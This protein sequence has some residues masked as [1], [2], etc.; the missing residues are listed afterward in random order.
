VIDHCEDPLKIL[1]NI[2]E[3]A[4]PG[5]YLYFWCDIWH[6]TGLDEGHHNITHSEAMMEK[7]FQG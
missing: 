4:A 5:C 1:H 6:L 7:I 3:Y 2:P